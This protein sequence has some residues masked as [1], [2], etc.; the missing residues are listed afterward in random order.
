MLS[1][2][3]PPAVYDNTSL[4]GQL[5]RPTSRANASLPDRFALM[6][7]SDLHPPV[8][9]QLYQSSQSQHVYQYTEEK[10]VYQIDN[11]LAPEVDEEDLDA[12]SSYFTNKGYEELQVNFV[13]IKSMCDCYSTSFQSYSALHRHI[14]SGCNTLRRIAVA[15]TG[16][17]P[18]SVRLVFYSTAKLSA[19]GSGLAFRGWSYATISIIFDLAILPYIGNPNTSVCLDTGCGVSLMDKT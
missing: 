19:L 3:I 8:P 6:P 11:D 16:S 10:E 9:R 12:N 1:A 15:K 2:A 5:L 7:L 13:G 14:K 18:P 4:V 17:D